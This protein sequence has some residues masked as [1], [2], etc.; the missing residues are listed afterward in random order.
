MVPLVLTLMVPAT[1]SATIY[2]CVS[3]LVGVA[4]GV[5]AVVAVESVIAVD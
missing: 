4:V 1:C 5:V 3:V 2:R